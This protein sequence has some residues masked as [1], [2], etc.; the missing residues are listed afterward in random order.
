[1]RTPHTPRFEELLPAYALG[2]LDGEDLRELAEHLAGGCDECRA[3]LALWQGDLEG[4]AASV[5]PVEPSATTRARVLRLAESAAAPERTARTPWAPAW[6]R[7][8]ALLLLVLAVW[9]L[10]GQSQLRDE[11]RSLSSERDRLLRQVAVLS[12]EMSRLHADVLQARQELQVLA[13]PGVQSV[14][15][16]GLG[17]SPG[18]KGHTYVNP[19]SRDALFYAFD[20]PRLPQDKTYQLWFIAGGKPVSAGVFSVDAKGV[21]RLRVDQVADVRQIQAWA[22]TIEP[23]GGVPQPTGAMVLKG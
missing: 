5:P 23:R 6:L 14:V 11:V 2:A 22:V 19:D 12:R 18:A 1:M 20:L 8:A 9:S 10:A 17:P 7:I 3:Q 16:A 13:A 21:G 15:L 4:L